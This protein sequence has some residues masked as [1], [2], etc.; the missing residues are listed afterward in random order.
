MRHLIPRGVRKR[1]YDRRLTRMRPGND[2]RA[3]AIVPEDF[4]LRE[5]ELERALDFVAVC[6]P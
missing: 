5:S 2:P 1:L 4:E 3:A 6:R